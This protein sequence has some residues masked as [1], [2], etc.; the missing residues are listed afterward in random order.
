MSQ[1]PLAVLNQLPDLSVDGLN[2][3]AQAVVFE[4]ARRAQEELPRP[5]PAAEPVAPEPA[6]EPTALEPATTEPVALEPATAEPAALSGSRDRTTPTETSSR[7]GAIRPETAP[8]PQPPPTSQ[9]AQVRVTWNGQPD[10]V[11]IN[12]DLED[13]P[14]M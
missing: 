3:L 1:P 13:D 2:I 11:M 9:G 5:E 6:A 8:P 7:A 4:L 14:L 10:V 12:S